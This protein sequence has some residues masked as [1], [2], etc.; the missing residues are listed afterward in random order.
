M[1]P[2]LIQCIQKHVKNTHFGTSILGTMSVGHPIKLL[3]DLV[4]QPRRTSEQHDLMAAQRV[5]KV[6]EYWPTMVDDVAAICDK[7]CR[8]EYAASMVKSAG[9]LLDDV[10][11]TSSLS[12]FL[13]RAIEQN[14]VSSHSL[15][16]VFF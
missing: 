9:K 11:R 16:C 1:T 10:M 13:K 6:L 15:R 4:V 3:S 7:M 2:E 8:I 14:I 12:T 5:E